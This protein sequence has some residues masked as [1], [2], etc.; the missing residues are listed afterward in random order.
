M[1]AN[2]H[3]RSRETPPRIRP[4]VVF[5]P[6]LLLPL[7]LVGP[8]GLIAQEVGPGTWAPSV[9]DAPSTPVHPVWEGASISALQGVSATAPHAF[10]LLPAD[11]T[12]RGGGAA[13]LPSMDWNGHFGYAVG[14]AVG[15]RHRVRPA[16]YDPW[17]GWGGFHRA[18]HPYRGGWSFAFGLGWPGYLGWSI[19][20]GAY[21]PFWAAP[22]GYASWWAPR[23]RIFVYHPRTIFAYH[24]RTVFV[25]VSRAA[26]RPAVWRTPAHAGASFAGRGTEFKEDPRTA[27]PATPGSG[28]TGRVAVPRQDASQA[29]GPPRPRAAPSPDLRTRIG[30]RDA[31]MGSPGSA[32]PQRATAPS[33]ARPSPGA[34]GPPST[35]PVPRTSAPPA[36]RSIPGAPTLPGARPAPG[37]SVPPGPETPAPATERGGPPAAEAPRSPARPPA[38]SP[39]TPAR[40][41][42]ASPRTPSQPPAASPRTPT[43][44]P[45]AS[46]RPP[47][48][49]PASAAPGA[50]RPA[51]SV[52]PSVRSRPGASSPR[53]ARPAPPQR[54]P[55]SR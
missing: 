32:G 47:A 45:A 53:P 21:Y 25:P 10:Q 26:Y 29:S 36:A 51:P 41:P 50:R 19:G 17:Y 31:A 54:R 33:A 42:A 18:C 2:P 13:A 7:G 20:Y 12:S 14:Y 27:Q 39:W 15:H 49:P 28:A 37:R 22:W 6:I 1:Y 3:P 8:L 4:S 30:T 55:S 48:R 9:R 11:G 38:A 40:P 52:G 34:A 23:H 46:P 24:P 5:A 35:G 16:C 44:P 43:R